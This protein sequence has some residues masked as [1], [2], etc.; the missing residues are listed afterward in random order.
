MTVTHPI[1][2]G[3]LV[4]ITRDLAGDDFPNYRRG[5]E[6]VVDEFLRAEDNTEPEPG[7]IG[8][9]FYYGSTDGGS[10]NVYAPA[11]ALEVVKTAAQMAARRIPTREQIRNE[12][13]S[14]LLDYF[15]TFETD[16][17]VRLGDAEIEVYGR[18][19]DGLGVGFR[20]KVTSAWQT[21]L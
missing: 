11:D 12:I 21:D 5:F 3:S 17:T 1:P 13:A 9:D 6:F 4:R 19:A 20:V 10:G 14:K 8:V 16:E 7:D 2:E 15:D 18:T